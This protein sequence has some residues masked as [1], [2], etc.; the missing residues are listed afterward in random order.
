[1]GVR[2]GH[3]EL[4]AQSVASRQVPPRWRVGFQ[5]PSSP[6]ESVVPASTLLD[7]AE[8]HINGRQ[9]HSA[10]VSFRSSVAELARV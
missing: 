3:V 7:P 9:S 10:S 1:M 6:E 4:A 8:G 2:S 5:G